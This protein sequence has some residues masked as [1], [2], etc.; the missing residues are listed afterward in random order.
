[1]T[2]EPVTPTKEMMPLTNEVL[3]INAALANIIRNRITLT[4][5]MTITNMIMMKEKSVHHCVE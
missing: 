5:L 4:Y 3:H 1:M 2:A